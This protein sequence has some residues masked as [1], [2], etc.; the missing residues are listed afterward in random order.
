MSL[1]LLG[2]GV[3]V[4]ACV[5]AAGWVDDGVALVL[6]GAELELELVELLEMTTTE[7]ELLV[8]TAIELELVTL[9]G[10]IEAETEGGV[11]LLITGAETSAALVAADVS[12]TQVDVEIGV[13]LSSSPAAT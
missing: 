11:L 3:G 13:G 12:S 8:V 7:L 10:V 6:D 2:V 5:I 1:W 9:P 4:G